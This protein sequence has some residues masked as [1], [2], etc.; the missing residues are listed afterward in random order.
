M[1]EPPVAE[2]LRRAARKAAAAAA[3]RVA[4]FKV[5]LSLL[6][7]SKKSV[8]TISRKLALARKELAAEQL[9][10]SAAALAK[11]VGGKSTVRKKIKMVRRQRGIVLRKLAAHRAMALKN[12]KC[13]QVQRA[14]MSK[15]QQR[16]LQA[17]LARKASKH[18]N[19][20][21]AQHESAV[22]QLHRIEKAAYQSQVQEKALKNKH[23]RYE[24]ALA[25]L[26]GKLTHVVSSME[27]KTVQKLIL[28]MKSK[29]ESAHAA[30]AIATQQ[31]KHLQLQRLNEVS[32]IAQ[33]LAAP[34]KVVPNV[35][36]QQ[37]A[38][39]VAKLP[40]A[41]QHRASAVRA[42]ISSILA[43]PEEQK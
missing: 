1:K 42:A 5:Q 7:R 3:G 13:V 41:H 14:L 15:V 23:R 36:Q 37:K 22:A 4:K 26:M 24:A 30:S 27:K 29:A 8:T 38:A 28:E 20:F 34:E 21:D 10:A 35:P 31:R 32:H 19:M 11:K 17:K 6:K 12:A 43:Q 40:A 39:G 16:Y 25:E 2:N 18:G 9:K 33:R